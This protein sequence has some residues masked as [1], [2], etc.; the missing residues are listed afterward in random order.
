[1]IITIEQILADAPFRHH[2]YK[3]APLSKEGFELADEYADHLARCRKCQ[4]ARVDQ[5]DYCP[6]GEKLFLAFCMVLITPELVP[7]N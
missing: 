2:V 1:M 3:L 7:T 6:V 4:Y 5:T